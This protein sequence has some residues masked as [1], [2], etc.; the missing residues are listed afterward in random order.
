[1]L[2]YWRTHADVT[3]NPD[4]D[5]Q[6][7]GTFVNCCSANYCRSQ[8]NALELSRGK[9]IPTSRPQISLLLPL[10]NTI[11]AIYEI[12]LLPLENTVAAIYEILLLPLSVISKTAGTINLSSLKW[13]DFPQFQIWPTCNAICIGSNFGHQVALLVLVANLA[14]GWCY[15]H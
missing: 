7:E 12:L 10:E 1:M 14:S 15:F 6:S 4:S 3:K 9:I 8:G 13:R 5:R 2:G 11:A